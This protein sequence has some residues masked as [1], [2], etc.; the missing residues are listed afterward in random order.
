MKANI[1]IVSFDV[2]GT[3]VGKEFTDSVW[4]RGI[5]KVYAEKE[6]ISFEKA[7]EIVK[8]EYDKLGENSIEWYEINHWL[9]ELKLKITREELFKRFEDEVKIYEEVE[10]VLKKLKEEG[11]ELIISSNAAKEF[12]EFQMHEILG[13][14]SHVF[15]ATS[16]FGKVKKSHDFYAKI[17]EILDVKPQEVVHTGDHF[18][19]DFFNPRRIGINAYYLDRTENVNKRD[20]FIISNLNEILGIVIH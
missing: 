14:F 2:D 11:Y 8:S 15:S 20:E 6:G 9:K 12:I 17:C 19:F 4:L 16:D 1:K 10:S 7:V 18:V 3:L 5:P 13:F